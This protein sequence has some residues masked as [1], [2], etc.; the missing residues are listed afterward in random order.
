MFGEN[1]KKLFLS[2]HEWYSFFIFNSLSDL[3]QVLNNFIC[4]ANVFL[5]QEKGKCEICNYRQQILE[6]R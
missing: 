3:I 2:H 4:I 5:D 1:V 6:N